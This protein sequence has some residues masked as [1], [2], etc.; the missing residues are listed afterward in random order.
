MK[1]IRFISL[2]CLKSSC[3]LVLTANV[4]L[5]S[6]SLPAHATDLEARQ[7]SHLPLGTNFAGIGYGYTKADI[8]LDPALQ[9]EN[10]E[11]RLQTVAAKYVRSFELLNKSARIDLTQ[12]YHRG[13]WE[14]L[15]GGTTA[16]VS[17]EG[18]SDSFARFAVNLIGAPP[19]K[20]KEFAAYRTNN[21]DKPIFGIG[22]AARL[23]TG[24]YMDDKLINLSENRFVVRPQIGGMK[25]WGNWTVEATTQIA[26]HTDNDD[27]FGGNT[28]EQDPLFITHA[29][30]I[31][32]I[33]PGLWA[34]VSGGLDY[35]GEKTVNGIKKD[36]KRKDYGYA[37]SFSYPLSRQYGI[38]TAYIGTRTN[39]ST[40]F[41]S[42]TLSVSLTALW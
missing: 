31:Y 40:G 30:M 24:E 27:F 33:K 7:W 8:A 25:S 37:L 26:L 41:D 32:T 2:L 18:L 35:G 12:S 4:L 1:V 15:L 9:I 19:L 34:A 22:L 39:E 29:H 36:D 14:G 3:S 6:V 21:N 23:P 20:G 16:S 28:L 11:M 42:D 10:G 17:R 13:K 38:K 5:I